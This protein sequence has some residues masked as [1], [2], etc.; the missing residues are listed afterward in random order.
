MSY[1]QMYDA[2]MIQKR[3]AR[4]L[5][6]LLQK[7]RLERELQPVSDGL[8]HISMNRE[9]TLKNPF[10]GPR[11][12]TDRATK[13]LDMIFALPEYVDL[14]FRCV[15]SDLPESAGR[16]PVGK[17]ISVIA[18]EG[19]IIKVRT[20]EDW[21]TLMLTCWKALMECGVKVSS[22]CPVGA[23]PV[24]VTEQF[25]TPFSY[26]GNSPVKTVTITPQDLAQHEIPIKGGKIDENSSWQKLLEIIQDQDYWKSKHPSGKR[27]PRGVDKMQPYVVDY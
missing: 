5:S 3:R 23:Q 19:A 24:A 11:L 14:D 22:K 26:E 6:L 20:P 15:I 17:E 13:A 1:Y 18:R 9:Q 16:F 4:Q 10:M 2:L 8:F 25:R 27:L 7:E 12:A 21:N